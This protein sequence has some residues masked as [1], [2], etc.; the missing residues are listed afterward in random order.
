MA[1]T[2][3]SRMFVNTLGIPGI[4][5]MIWLGGLWFTIFTSVVMLLAIREFYQIN[6]TQDSSPMLWLGWIATLGI[7]MMYDN[8]VTLVDNYLII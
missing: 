3:S 6:S 4:L 7:V 5:I 8:S 2:L 1:D